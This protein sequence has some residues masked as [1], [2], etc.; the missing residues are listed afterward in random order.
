[1]PTESHAE[2]VLSK[3]DATRP[4]DFSWGLN[5]QKTLSKNHVEA[6]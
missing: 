6:L 3:T 4:R 2:T 1:M 5:S